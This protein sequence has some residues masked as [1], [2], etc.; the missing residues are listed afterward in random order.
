VNRT[1][2]EVPPAPPD[3]DS[4]EEVDA[5]AGRR[6]D[7]RKAWILAGSLALGCAASVAVEAPPWVGI[8]A[9]LLAAAARAKASRLL[10]VLILLGGVS[11][12]GIRLAEPVPG[13][14]EKRVAAAPGGV[15]HLWVRGRLFSLESYAEGSRG[16]LRIES[17][18]DNE[19]WRASRERVRVYLPIPP[20]VDGARLEAS[21]RFRRPGGATN[22]GQFN[23]REFLRRKGIRLVGSVTRRALVAVEEPA[24]PNPL[25]AYRRALG[26]A[27]RRDTGP[28]SGVVCAL[29]LGDRGDLDPDTREALERSGLFHLVAL[30]GLHVGLLLILLMAGCHLAGIRPLRRDWICLGAIV[31]YGLIVAPRASFTR[32]GIMAA[33]YVLARVL[34]RPGA[35]WHAFLWAASFLLL[36]NPLW[37][38]DTGFQMTFLGTLGILLLYGRVPEAVRRLPGGETVIPLL[39]VGFSA[40]LGVLP[41]LACGFHRV[42]LVGWLLTPLAV[43]PVMALQGAGLLY[44][45]GGA[46]VPGLHRV[47]GWIME[48]AARLFLVLP[49][50]AAR[51]RWSSLFLPSPSLL[52][53][54]L[55]F[56]GLAMAGLGRR[57]VRTVGWVLLAFSCVGAWC[58]PVPF[59]A[60]RASTLAVLDVG[61]ASCQVI[62]DGDRT[63]LVDAGNGVFRGPS[64]GRRVVEP[65]LAALGIRSLD[66]VFLTHWD[67]DHAGSAEGLLRTF[68]TGFL[69]YPSTDPPPGGDDGA[70]SRLCRS[71][72]I[73]LIPLSRGN[74]VALPW[75]SFEVLHP[76]AASPLGN[77]NERSLVLRCSWRGKRLLF[78]GDI[79]GEAER[80][81]CAAGFL[82]PVDI[83]LVPHH[84]SG[85]AST[86]AFI[87][88]VRPG[89]SIISVGRNNAFHHPAE[90]TLWRYRSRHLALDRTDRHGAV[91]VVFREGRYT[92]WRMCDGDWSHRAAP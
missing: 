29:L 60:D 15:F 67:K 73:R 13:P 91:A 81:L 44:M 70:L 86:G 39:W 51:W 2:Q 65:F 33:A 49:G 20:V 7:S 80:E 35:G 21:V 55:F 45:A 85:A 57:R 6:G 36:L 5:P 4:L 28:H 74:R 82:S 71:K 61:Q 8:A 84:G 54:G 58:V 69:A 42:S 19:A 87:D 30:S 68:P 63:L 18:W 43:L 48:A 77:E 90:R 9:L 50:E 79:G 24:F 26:A 12:G 66:G 78:T 76:D 10:P 17:Y 31:L 16:E 40:Q 23:G 75:I 83:L 1:E 25:A 37:C 46:F 88:A 92:V 62:C 53:V 22:P 72:G 14:V 47:L 3:S 34:A 89:R 56:T 41:I 64:S 52:W 32:A 59:R 27:I 11:W 38:L